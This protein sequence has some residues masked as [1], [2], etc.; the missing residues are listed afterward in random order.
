MF[1]VVGKGRLYKTYDPK[2]IRTGK[3]RV[4]EIQSGQYLLGGP[5][6]LHLSCND[7]ETKRNESGSNT[8]LKQIGTDSHSFKH[9][10]F[11]LIYNS[12]ENRKKRDN[13]YKTQ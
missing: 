6:L 8:K 11:S 10:I 13:I 4:R 3:E 9:K 1:W 5:W 2:K 12:A 7:E